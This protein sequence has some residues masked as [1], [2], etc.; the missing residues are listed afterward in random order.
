VRGQV[1]GTLNI[2]TERDVLT[3]DEVSMLYTISDRLSQAMESAR[4]FEAVQARAERERVSSELTRHIRSST[5]I[6]T[7]MQTAI[8]ELSEVLHISKG[9]IQLCNS[10]GDGTY[11]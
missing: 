4:L 7:I 8:Q 6:D 3:S 10:N 1:I 9:V 2:W 11:G 5:N